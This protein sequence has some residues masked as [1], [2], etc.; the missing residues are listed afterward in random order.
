MDPRSLVAGPLFCAEVLL[1]PAERL[2]HDRGDSALRYARSLCAGFYANFVLVLQV[3]CES[4]SLR[5]GL[6]QLNSTGG[7]SSIPFK[8]IAAC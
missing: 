7:R 1:A 3:S 5:R 8:L 6:Q 4:A 2:L